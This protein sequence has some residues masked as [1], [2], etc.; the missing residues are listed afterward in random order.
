MKRSTI[1][2]LIAAATAL[3]STVAVA[4]DQWAVVKTMKLDPTVSEYLAAAPAEAG[5]F[6]VAGAVLT[7]EVI[8][9]EPNGDA[10]YGEYNDVVK[11]RKIVGFESDGDAIY[12]GFNGAAL[13]LELTPEQIAARDAQ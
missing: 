1:A 6:K 2:G 5:G 11:T 13:T 10:I 4:E 12:G 8:G 3:T 9:I 7:R